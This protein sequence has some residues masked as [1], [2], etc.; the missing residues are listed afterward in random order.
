VLAV[1]LPLTAI[2]SAVLNLYARTHPGFVA[3]STIISDYLSVLYV[4]VAF[5][6]IVMGARGLNS[7]TRGRPSFVHT[8]IIVVV[9]IVLG[10][11]FCNLVAHAHQSLQASYHMSYSLVMLTFAIPYMYIWYMGLSAVAELY[12]Y[13]KQLAGVLYRKGWNRVAFGL[14]TIITLDIALQY[15]NTLG[16]WLNSLS[17]AGLLGLL[18][19]LL[20]L[21]AVGFIVVALG[22]KELMKIEEA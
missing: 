18:Y 15:L 10:V 3:A 14:G 22:T 9:V 8:Q 19:V 12:V 1:G 7:Y 20:F 4:L 13:S 21:L 6:F 11:I 5:I 17:L 16:N 2:V